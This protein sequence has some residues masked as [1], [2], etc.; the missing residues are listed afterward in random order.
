MPPITS[1]QR[2]T[3]PE[4]AGTHTESS[5][6][7]LDAVIVGAGFAGLYML[8][9]LNGMGLKARIIEAAPDVGGTW[10]WNRY[11]GARCDIESMQY[12][13]QF[14]EELQQEWNWKERYSAQPEILSYIQHVADRFN[15]RQHI[16]FGTRVTAA[17]FNDD[18]SQW[19][20]QTDAGENLKAR[21][22]IMAVGCLSTTIMPQTEG[23]F[24]FKGPVY[25]TGKWP[26]GGVDFTGKKVGV[27]GTGS[28]GVQIIPHIAEQAEQL[29]VFQRTAGY[30]VPAQNRPLDPEEVSEIKRNYSEL[31]AK[32]KAHPIA[33]IF[34]MHKDSALGA[35]EEERKVR[36]EDQWK[37]G[38]LPFAAAYG[39]LLTNDDA[40]KLVVEF[41]KTKMREIVQDPKI[42]EM[43]TPNQVYGCKR[44]PSGTNYFETYNRPN[45]TLVDVS[46]TGVEKFTEKGIVAKGQE[47]ELDVIVM[48]TGFDALTGSVVSINITGKNDEKIN[49]KWRNG[50]S[51]YMGLAVSGFPNMFN[52]L[53]PGCPSVLATM[54]TG[55]EQQGDWIADCIGWMDQNAKSTIEAD[56]DSETAWVKEVHDLGM[57]SIRSTCNSWY[58]GANVPGKPHVFMPYAGG[59]N[60]YSARCDKVAKN[61]YKGFSFS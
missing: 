23:T 52:M 1:E 10:Y 36:F 28:S 25:H 7:Q 48:A 12:S 54:V 20:V 53:G 43:L 11:P 50:P 34:P 6:E 27:I 39:D 33:F 38:G 3:A 16:D 46:G 37:V 49:D 58:V 61:N 51:N 42:A 9:K 57:K 47:H 26:A 15:L 31:R 13:Y 21:F 41:W 29:S 5:A 35:T 22:F 8:H 2:A 19:A 59:F 4:H 17:T 40:N 44:I 60:N 24:D 45:V 55:A 56:L 18:Q 30:V 14:S 32:A